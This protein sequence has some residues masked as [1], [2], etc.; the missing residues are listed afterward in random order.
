VE[1]HNQH[2]LDPKEDSKN[3]P[4]YLSEQHI[5]EPY[6]RIP[7]KEICMRYLQRYIRYEQGTEKLVGICVGFVYRVTVGNSIS[8]GLGVRVCNSGQIYKGTTR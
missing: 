2:G 6:R 8:R 4:I 3:N 7:W 5:R 1:Q